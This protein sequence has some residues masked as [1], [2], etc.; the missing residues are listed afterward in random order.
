MLALGR[1]NRDSVTAPLASAGTYLAGV[2][3]AIALLTAG[4][5][6]FSVACA[7]LHVVEIISDEGRDLS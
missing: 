3:R 4:L 6:L 7:I 2:T 1:W 5:S